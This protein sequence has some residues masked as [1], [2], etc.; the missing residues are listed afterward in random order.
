MS[1]PLSCLFRS[2]LHLALVCAFAH[3]TPTI[4]ADEPELS[5][6]DDWSI[7]LVRIDSGAFE[8]GRSSGGSFAAAALSFGEQ[9]DWITEGPVRQVT[10]SKPFFIGKYKI[11]TEQFCRFLNS[12]DNPGQYIDLNTFSSIE[13]RGGKYVPQEGKDHYPMNVVH[14]DGATQFCKWLSTNSG[15]KVR[16]PTEAEWEYVARGTDG[17]KVP[18]G[19]KEI[20]SWTSS[21]GAAVDAFPE[22]ST[23][24]GVVG[25]VDVRVG[26]WCSDFYGVRYLPDDTK[27]PQGPSKEQLPVQSDVRWLGTVSGEYHVQRGRV[28]SPYWSTTSR[29]LGSR[30]SGAG[31]YGFR[32]VVELEEKDDLP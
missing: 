1:R 13:I 8:M 15:R 2:S 5:V 17:R 24:E 26:E 12:T 14:W 30:V 22:N 10:I 6:G 32:I 31:I 3:S 16:L 7:P 29:T 18:W 20:S 25:L 4:R 23:P 11:T 9:G 21:N 19:N 28:K 27:D